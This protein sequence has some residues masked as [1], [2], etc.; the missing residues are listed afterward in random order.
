MAERGSARRPAADAAESRE[1]GDYR[2]LAKL[3][4]GGQADVYLALARGPMDVKRLAVIK[5]LR[6]AHEFHEEHVTMFL[7]E[8]RLAARL[9]HANVVTTYEVGRANDGYFIAMEYLDGQPLEQVMRAPGSAGHFTHRMWAAIAADALAG[10]HYAHELA[11]YDGTPLGIVHRDVSPHNIFLTYAG[12]TKLVDFGVAKASLNTVKT[13][14]GVLKGKVTYMS[15]E[16]ARGTTTDRRSDLF[17]MGIILWE[18]VTGKR[19]FVGEALTILNK[20]INEPVPPPSSTDPSVPPALDAIIARALAMSPDDRFQ[21]AEEMRNALEAYIRDTGPPIS[22]RD[23]GEAL[24]SM[25]GD[26]HA[27]VRE[28]IAAHMAGL[29]SGDS[30]KVTSLLDSEPDVPELSEL[31]QPTTASSPTDSLQAGEVDGRARARRSLAAPLAVALVAAI[32]I[33]GLVMYHRGGP[34]VLPAAST[35]I[36]SA[37]AA[38]PVTPTLRLASDPPEADVSWNGRPMGK[39]PLELGLPVG[40][41]TLVVS[42]AGFDEEP[43]VVELHAGDHDVARS[44]TL[45]PQA[46]VAAPSASAAP[47]AHAPS[48]RPSRPSRPVSS[49]GAAPEPTVPPPAPTDSGPHRVTPKDNW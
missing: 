6:S 25:F 23:L 31:L 47:S 10:L 44:V 38:P 1:L 48:S 9:T 3:G 8:A 39:T 30:D 40:A 19:L 32:G 42:K 37:A 35:P 7:D 33:A 26:A 24:T 41:Q 18:A 21:T 27:H 16:Q 45:R 14:T 34:S 15:P 22:R 17:A 36:A 11:D 49:G 29:G 43:L 5:R 28:R 46:P 12:E 13:E 4:S 2:L 20:L